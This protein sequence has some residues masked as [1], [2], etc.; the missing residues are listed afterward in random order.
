[1]SLKRNIVANYASQLCVTIIGIITLP[2][3]IKY[4]GAE[5]YGLVGFFTMLQAWFNL[6]DLGLTP[7]IARETARFRAGI[8]STTSYLRL[9]R[10]L[11]IIFLSIAFVGGS[12][13]FFSSN[14][15]SENWLT[16]KELANQEVQL[17]IQIMAISV[18]LRW[19][20]GL[21][22]GVVS[23]SE[24]LVWLSIFNSLIAIL[25]FIVVFPVLFYFGAETTV[26]FTY[27]LFVAI[28][29]F[30]GLQYKAITLLPK[31]TDSQ[32]LG[33]SLY[34]IKPILGFSLTIAFSSSLWVI[35]TQSDRLLMSKLLT[36]EEYGYFTLAV[37]VASSIMM[38]SG[39]ISN[40]IMPRMAKL[41]AEGNI[42]ELIRVY[43][44]A[45]QLVVIIA[46]SAALILITFSK[47]ILFL[48]TQNQ[49]IADIAAPVMELYAAGYA[50]V[51]VGAFPYYLQYAK[52]KLQLHVLGS[53]LYALV[54]IPTLFF[55]TMHFGMIGAG[56]AWLSTNILY[57]LVWSWVVHNKLIKNMHLKWLFIDI[58]LITTPSIIFILINNPQ[59]SESSINQIN[60]LITILI[61]TILVTTLS[62]L[63]KKFSQRYFNK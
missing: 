13:L 54:L 42:N 26:F 23:G 32:K 45:T 30:I 2:L 37:L 52:G 51:A 62:A 8:N 16:F 12:A 19:M 5:A 11:N 44:A 61:Y 55:S 35:V 41:E 24:K 33:W 36:L 63:S 49:H 21:Y 15:I 56:Y 27:Q 20:T 48:W 31:N 40:A 58:M 28:I 50:L 39:P 9:F 29:E 17:A 59:K 10:A 6:L 38:V 60:P 46:G 1:M 25:R 53:V 34:A 22:R 47:S 7:T 57:F 43:R 4:M 18:S 3:Y 14:L